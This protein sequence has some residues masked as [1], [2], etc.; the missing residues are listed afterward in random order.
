MDI[1]L[2]IQVFMIEG[3]WKYEKKERERKRRKG[4]VKERE[5]EREKERVF[6][7]VLEDIYEKGREWK[8]KIEYRNEIDIENPEFYWYQLI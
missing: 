7:W 5:R 1:I 4:R 8:D 2:L 6:K 3:D